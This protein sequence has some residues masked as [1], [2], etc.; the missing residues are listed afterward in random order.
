MK[1]YFRCDGGSR[2]GL[3][4]LVR[5]LALAGML[6]PEYLP[7]FLVQEPDLAIVTLLEASGVAFTAL[8]QT[9]NYHQEAA[10]LTENIV[11]AGDL[12]VLDGYYF[13]TAYQQVLK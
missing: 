7:H 6:Q 10:F 1:I 11:D 9:K 8:P 13:N 12:V 5:S 2:I 4:H 3:G